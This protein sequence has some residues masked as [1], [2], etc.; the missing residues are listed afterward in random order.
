MEV[1]KIRL[2]KQA[3]EIL[4]PEE[5][6]VLGYYFSSQPRDLRSMRSLLGI[7]IDR[8]KETLSSLKAK[9]FVTGKTTQPNTIELLS[10]ALKVGG[11]EEVCWL[12]IWALFHIKGKGGAKLLL[13]YSLREKNTFVGSVSELAAGVGMKKRNANY[14]LNLLV[15]NKIITRTKVKQRVEITLL[16][17][18]KRNL[19]GLLFG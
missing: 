18:P 15:K 2:P 17:Q 5:F 9:G 13:C 11:D 8:I 7:S 3:I 19:L 1:A 6:C 4:T 16:E 14:L 12:P 10:S